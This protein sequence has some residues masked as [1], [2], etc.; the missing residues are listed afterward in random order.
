MT[1]D[2][3]STLASILVELADDVDDTS[4]WMA[5]A[6]ALTDCGE[7]VDLYS[8][9][10]RPT[11]LCRA[12]ALTAPTREGRS[13]VEDVQLHATYVEPGYSDR[14]A[15]TPIAVG[16]WNTI[17]RYKDGTREELDDTP[18]RLGELL[19]ALGCPLEWSDEW[20]DCGQC[21]GLV[22]TQPN[23]WGWHPAYEYHEG[24][25]TCH[26]CR[27]PLPP[28]PDEMVASY[29]ET[30]L[31]ACTDEDGESL[32]DLATSLTDEAREQLR[33]D[34]HDFRA[35]LPQDLLALVDAEPG[36]AGQDL[37]LT[38]NGCGSGFWD[39]GWPSD[40]E[41]RLTAHAHQQGTRDLYLGD[42]GQIQTSP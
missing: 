1:T 40:A 37:F 13:R 29:V 42:D 7:V 9:W 41:Q 8:L 27:P 30:A 33:Q 39:G 11:A 26:G 16:D 18:K 32:Q 17:T 19:E 20:T 24:E 6:D 14:G 2:L 5:L 4:S 28:T 21:G 23:S 31:W 22:R 12:A 35:A 10:G 36:Q 38:R 3:T 34:C 15:G 25:V